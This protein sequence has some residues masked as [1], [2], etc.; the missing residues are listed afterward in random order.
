M[1]RLLVLLALLAFSGAA[2]ADDEAPD[3][4]DWDRYVR[5]FRR[6]HNFALSVG[7][8]SG[9]WDVRRFGNIKGQKYKTSGA[10]SRFQYSF[11]LP[12]YQGFGYMLGSSFGY[13]YE[14][15]DKRKPFHPV[16][17]LMF[18]G[19][20]IGIVENF[21]PVFRWSLAFDAYME[22]LNDLAERDGQTISVTMEAFDFGTF[23]D[24]FYDLG[25]AVRLE[26]HHRHHAYLKPVCSKNSPCDFPVN[27]NF[28]KDDDWVGLG[29][30]HHLL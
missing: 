23:I 6:D 20:M 13:H 10:W 17:A 30:V 29:L 2:A 28:R 7:A 19:A 21:N 9:T 22:R 12:L 18:P 16:P 4:A 11:H 26:G 8:G 25:W 1:R 24:F 3:R 27:A 14:S 5:G 15:A